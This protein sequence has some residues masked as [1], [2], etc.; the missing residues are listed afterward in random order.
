[1]LTAVLLAILSLRAVVWLLGVWLIGP[2][3]F[4]AGRVVAYALVFAASL[5][6]AIGL[7]LL[8]QW[9]RRLALAL[10]SCY[11]ALLVAGVIIGWAGAG[12]GGIDPGRTLAVLLESAVVAGACWFYLT[13][14]DVLV[15]FERP[16]D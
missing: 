14:P 15:L 12:S 8:Q 5:A 7:L 10:C 13:R 2:G 11:A 4:G 1:M 3:S 9:A 16:A 6:S